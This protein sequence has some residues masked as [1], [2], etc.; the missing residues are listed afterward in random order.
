MPMVVLL[1]KRVS[2]G[3]APVY[4]SHTRSEAVWS[5]L[6][7]NDQAPTRLFVARFS[8]DL[9]CHRICWSAPT[10]VWRD[11]CEIRY[12]IIPLRVTGHSYT[13]NMAVVQLC[14]WSITST[15]V[16]AG[17]NSQAKMSYIT[18]TSDINLKVGRSRC[19]FRLKVT[20]ETDRT[21]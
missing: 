9:V 13:F 3:K 19:A 21:K 12:K 17:C 4:Q 14:D 16:V 5:W 15:T 10:N 6:T 8:I 1:L 18:L 11:F 20:Q 7:Y 2:E